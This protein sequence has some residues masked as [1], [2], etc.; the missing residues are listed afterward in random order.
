MEERRRRRVYG[1]ISKQSEGRDRR[2][3]EKREMEKGGQASQG[4][5][6]NETVKR[7]KR[8]HAPLPLCKSQRR[9]QLAPL[10][11]DRY[12]RIGLDVERL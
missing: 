1:E 7:E 6:A 12:L 10:L 2:E 4:V 5:N 3:K 8:D 9:L 11:G